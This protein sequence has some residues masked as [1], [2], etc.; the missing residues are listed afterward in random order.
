MVDICRCVKTIDGN[1]IGAKVRQL[2]E[3]VTVKPFVH[4]VNHKD[5]TCYTV[6]ITNNLAA[7]II[8]Q[9]IFNEREESTTVVRG[10]LGQTIPDDLNRKDL[11]VKLMDFVSHDVTRFVFDID[12]SQQLSSRDKIS[13]SYVANKLKQH[14]DKN[15]SRLAQVTAYTVQ[16]NN[17][18]VKLKFCTFT[19]VSSSS[20]R[21]TIDDVSH[22]MCNDGHRLHTQSLLYDNRSS[23]IDLIE[24][25]GKPSEDETTRIFVIPGMIIDFPD[26]RTFFKQR[27]QNVSTCGEYAT[28]EEI[29]SD[30]G[31]SIEIS[32]P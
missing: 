1:L 2:S 6:F 30:N 12:I 11:P 22:V 9:K 16:K 32:K 25:D 8:L 14:I 28:E 20:Q 31:D 18:I 19:A 26:M 27:S 13:P 3:N 7:R 24:G 5:H 29:D 21:W 15:S 4:Y 23:V 10:D 17:V